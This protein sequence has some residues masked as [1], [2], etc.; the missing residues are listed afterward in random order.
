MNKEARRRGTI[1]VTVLWSVALL[2]ALAMAA[3]TTF[4]GFAN[5]LGVDRDTIEADALLTGGVE[6][7]ASLVISLGDIPLRD[8]ET[9]VVMSHGLVHMTLSDQ[10]GRIDIGR[11]SVELLTGLFHSIGGSDRQANEVAR[12]IVEWR[13]NEGRLGDPSKRTDQGANDDSPFTDARQLLQISDVPPEWVDAI[14][15]LITVYGNATINPLTAPAE[16]IAALPGISQASLQ[17][18]LR[19]RDSSPTDITQAQTILAAAQQ[20][21]EVKP[22]KV[23]SVRLAAKLADR[24]A[25]A[26]R[27][28]I[29][30]LPDDAEPYRIL[31]WNPLP[32]GSNARP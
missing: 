11:A 2:S 30:V 24:F 29:V 26:A 16:V 9:T 6:A 10:G 21:L 12:R 20:Y 14:A 15:P 17:T 25:S 8:F 7:A 28:V 1:L 19:A 22:T 32:S 27:C 18:F 4:R 13:A 5:I 23:V 31:V 3:S